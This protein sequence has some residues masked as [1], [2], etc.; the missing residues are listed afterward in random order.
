MVT[1]QQLQMTVKTYHASMASLVGV[2]Q[3]SGLDSQ[4][5]QHNGYA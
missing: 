5:H 1:A 4:Y 2:Q 3:S